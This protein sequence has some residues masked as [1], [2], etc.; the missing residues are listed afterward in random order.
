MRDEVALVSDQ[1]SANAK[2]PSLIHRIWLP[3]IIILA[4]V[5]SVV[6]SSFLGYWLII[7]IEHA[8]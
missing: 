2:S 5:L 6:W 4:L 8:L 1:Q 3:A 7:V